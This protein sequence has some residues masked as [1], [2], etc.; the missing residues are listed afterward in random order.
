MVE[1]NRVF[2][3]KMGDQ[4]VV[5]QEER[6]RG[7]RL[8]TRLGALPVAEDILE[9]GVGLMLESSGD[10]LDED[11]DIFG[12]FDERGKVR[13]QPCSWSAAAT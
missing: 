13:E 2:L 10:C 9:D 8:K 6:K 4:V 5:C 11:S 7:A 3:I 1:I 12:E